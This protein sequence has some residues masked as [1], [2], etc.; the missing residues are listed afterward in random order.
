MRPG[1]ATLQKVNLDLF[2]CINEEGR[3]R[4]SVEGTAFILNALIVSQKAIET[5]S[6][7]WEQSVHAIEERKD[8]SYHEA[9]MNNVET[10]IQKL[11]KALLEHDK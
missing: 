1:G 9:D 6:M 11:Q 8:Y 5:Q 10:A 2:M 7:S 4:V 3:S